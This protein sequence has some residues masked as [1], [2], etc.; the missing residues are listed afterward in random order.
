MLPK[1]EAGQESG[2]CPGVPTD[3]R[4]AIA[5]N[6]QVWCVQGERTDPDVLVLRLNVMNTLWRERLTNGDAQRACVQNLVGTIDLFFGTR[7]AGTRFL[8]NFQPSSFSALSS[9]D[10]DPKFSAAVVLKIADSVT[11]HKSRKS[12]PRASALL[13]ATLPNLW[14]IEN[15]EIRSLAPE[16]ATLPTSRLIDN[17]EKQPR[18][19][20]LLRTTRPNSM[21]PSLMAHTFRN[22]RG[23]SR[24]PFTDVELDENTTLF[25][26]KRVSNLKL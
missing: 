5:S 18:A 14:P 10:R 20:A 23:T 16:A 2:H 1:S 13:P 11:Y 22:I 12:Q 19:S 7:L 21:P 26:I 9:N 24:H 3:I 15:R 17:R 8:S 25:G 6:L 4:L